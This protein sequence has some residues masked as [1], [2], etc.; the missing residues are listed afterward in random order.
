MLVKMAR[1]NSREKGHLK[2]IMNDTVPIHK[3]QCSTSA[4][5]IHLRRQLFT[6]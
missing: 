3:L 6:K 1:L 4:T 5:I 2:Q